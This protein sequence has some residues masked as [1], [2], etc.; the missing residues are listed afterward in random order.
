V[1]N[2]QSILSPVAV[3]DMLGVDSH[4]GKVSRGE[5][6]LLKRYLQSRNGLTETST[7]PMYVCLL[8]ST[9]VSVDH[10]NECFLRM[11]GPYV[12]LCI[13]ESLLQILIYCFVRDLA[14]QC[15]IRNPDFL[16]L[17]GI[18]CR[19]FDIWFAAARSSRTPTTIMSFRSFLSFRAPAYS[20]CTSNVSHY[21]IAI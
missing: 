18:E 13:L 9:Q 3:Q 4:C 6:S 17:G 16:L 2:L 10:R 19:L 7:C 15:K 21:C 14:D 12:D 20:L 11:K 5:D 1:T 8:V